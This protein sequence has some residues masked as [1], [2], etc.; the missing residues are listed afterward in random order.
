MIK[1]FKT[2]CHTLPE[3]NG[4]LDLIKDQVYYI[5][6]ELNAYGRPGRYYFSKDPFTQKDFDIIQNHIWSGIGLGYMY[7]VNSVY[8][9]FMYQ[10]DDPK[11]I[12]HLRELAIDK[13]I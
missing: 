2:V 7:L 13:I 6:I 1:T 4:S 9:E 5:W 12:T 11:L 10:E 8:D 3:Y